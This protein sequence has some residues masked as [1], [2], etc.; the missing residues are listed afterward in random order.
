MWGWQDWRGEHDEKEGTVNDHIALAQEVEQVM[1]GKL[2]TMWWYHM[3][4]SSL[5]EKILQVHFNCSA[6]VT[7]MTYINMFE[8]NN[9][10]LWPQGRTDMVTYD[11]EDLLFKLDPPKPVG[12]GMRIQHLE[13]SEQNFNDVAGALKHVVIMEGI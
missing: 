3:E 12:T 6:E 4:N 13:F 7:C 2:E 9:K 11:K 5:Q 10:F 8:Q 1:S